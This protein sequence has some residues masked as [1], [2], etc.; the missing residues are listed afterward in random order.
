MCF[1]IRDE[2]YYYVFVRSVL[3]LFPIIYE[4]FVPL[5]IIIIIERVFFEKLFIDFSF[6]NIL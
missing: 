4:H 1:A 6:E 3:T 5:D 2:E